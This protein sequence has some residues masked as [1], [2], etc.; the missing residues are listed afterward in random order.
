MSDESGTVT[1]MFHQIQDS[2]WREPALNILAAIATASRFT[3]VEL[4]IGSEHGASGEMFNVAR[5]Y[6]D[7]VGCELASRTGKNPAY[8]YLQLGC[9]KKQELAM[10][11]FAKACVGKPFSQSAM[12]RHMAK[13]NKRKQLFLCRY[14]EQPPISVYDV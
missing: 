4:A 2:W 12:V 9:S 11:A 7:E 3:H 14:D 13:E 6:N 8:T 5:V 10:L 1:L